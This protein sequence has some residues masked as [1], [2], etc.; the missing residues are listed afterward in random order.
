[1]GNVENLNR[2]GRLRAVGRIHDMAL[3]G[4]LFRTRALCQCLRLRVSD[5]F[6]KFI[7]NT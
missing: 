7:L 5:E 6:P 1:M 4:F 3:L 2:W